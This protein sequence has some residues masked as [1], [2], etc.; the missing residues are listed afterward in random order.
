[1]PYT[2]EREGIRTVTKRVPET[3]TITVRGGHWETQTVEVPSCGSA[4][5]ECGECVRTCCKR[6][7]VPT[8]EEKEIECTTY[9][10]VSEDVPYTYNVCLTRE[11]ERTHS[12]CA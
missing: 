9:K 11:E 7:W 5:G 4:C 2:E 8:C 12:L 3:K 1:V 6:V 10:C